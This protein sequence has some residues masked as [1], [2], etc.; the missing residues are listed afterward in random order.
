MTCMYNTNTNYWSTY[1]VRQQLKWRKEFSDYFL[2]KMNDSAQP[3]WIM[4]VKLVKHIVTV[5]K[6]NAHFPVMSWNHFLHH[7]IQ[8]S[9]IKSAFIQR[10][11]HNAG[12][13]VTWHNI[14]QDF[15][16]C[17]CKSQNDYATYSAIPFNI[18]TTRQ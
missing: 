11:L 5:W 9:I 13:Q 17:F 8:I 2:S 7:Y 1:A 10:L 15:N 3:I 16:H 4:A 12:N 6:A 14:L 18:P